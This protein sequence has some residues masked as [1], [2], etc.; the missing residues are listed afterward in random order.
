[1]PCEASRTALQVWGGSGPTLQASDLRRDCHGF[2]LQFRTAA[3]YALRPVLLRT[4][5]L[6]TNIIFR[7]E[8]FKRLA[9][10]YKEKSVR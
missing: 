8:S 2:A 6:L 5:L 10:H 3:Q 9:E 1:M 4:I 7:Y